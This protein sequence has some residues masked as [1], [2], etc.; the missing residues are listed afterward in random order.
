MRGMMIYHEGADS[1]STYTRYRGLVSAAQPDSLHGIFDDLDGLLIELRA[2][3]GPKE[4]EVIWPAHGV[5]IR[6]LADAGYSRGCI[7]LV[8]DHG[9]PNSQWQG[10]GPRGGHHA[11]FINRALSAGGGEEGALTAAGAREA[12]AIMCV[13]AYE[14]ENWLASASHYE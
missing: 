12:V 6:R 7:D 2:A 14:T 11:G 8:V 9:L 4:L 5:D 3:M 1:L 13:M 10:P